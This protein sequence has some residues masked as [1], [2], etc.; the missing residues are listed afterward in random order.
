MWAAF[1]VAAGF[2]TYFVTRVKAALAR[3]DEALATARAQVERTERLTSLATLAAGAAHELGTPLS[4]I[5]VVARDLEEELG[6]LPAA[7]TLVEDARLVRSEVDRCRAV[8]EQL[9]TEAGQS[10]GEAP[11]R[12]SLGA[13]VGTALQGLERRDRVRVEADDE[14]VLVHARAVGRALRSLVNNALDASPAGAAVDVMART[15]GAALDLEV[16]DRGTG[17][18]EEVLVRATEP[19]FTTKEPG[20]GMGLGLF[21]ARSVAERLGGVLDL[22]S[23]PGEGT[24]V[25][26]H[27][28]LEGGRS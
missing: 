22:E 7:A 1:A 2:T 15:A 4:T 20:K 14:E 3:R 6:A 16:R 13:L 27:L 24:R 11:Q 17:M 23:T 8:L 10:A 21:L 25:T 12:V 5:A 28:P 19:F 18:S 9:A 26:L